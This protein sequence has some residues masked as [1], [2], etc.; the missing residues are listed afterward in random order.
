M[1]TDTQSGRQ[2]RSTVAGD[3]E[4]S[5]DRVSHRA[6]RR[7]GRVLTDHADRARGEHGQPEQEDLP[8]AREAGG[9][10][11]RAAELLR[12]LKEHP[13]ITQRPETSAPFME[14]HETLRRARTL[15]E[16]C[17]HGGYPRQ[18]CAG[19]ARAASLRDVQGRIDS[20]LRLFPI[21]SHLDSTRLLVQVINSAAIRDTNSNG[22]TEEDMVWSH[23]N[24]TYMH[25]DHSRLQN[26][27]F[28]QL[29]TATD[30]F[31]FENQ[32]EQGPL[33]TL[34]KGNLCGNDVT[35]RKLLVSSSGQQL[36]TSVSGYQ[37]FENEV[38]ILPKL[39]HKNIVKLL[40]FCA[41]RSERILV[42]EYMQNGSLEDVIFGMLIFPHKY[43]RMTGGLTV[44]WPTRFRIVEGV[45]QG[46]IYL[47][48]HS[49]HRIIHRDLKPSN[50]LLD[51]DMNPRITNFDLAKIV[52]EDSD[53]GTAEC[54][55]GSVG[56]IAPEYMEKGTY[57]VKTDVYS[58]G[59]MI[60]EII[61]GK[62]WTKPFQETYYKD[63]RTWAFKKTPWRGVKLEQRLKG[64]IHPS[65]HS[66]SFVGRIV[67]RCLSFP[68][69]RTILS[70]QKEVRRC[71]RVALLCIQQNPERRPDM[72]EAAR[73]LRPRKA[74]VPFPR[75]PGY[76]RESPMY[77]GDRA[78]T[79]A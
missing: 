48:N 18:L 60:L 50:V 55:V 25:D 3:D 16:S 62:R 44:E 20:F 54:V 45:A 75:R 74:R 11:P 14:L 52:S 6:G 59:V 66:V 10:D 15:V 73:M 46:A 41:E 2:R 19:G 8:A 64:F 57:S 63:V 79:T 29:T 4:R 31:S 23:N 38:K 21:I 12:S 61:S 32:I 47:H 68:V 69:R 40:G 65:L 56:F 24:N 17:Q 77:A 67:P 7:R 1:H 36:P 71:I 13:G 76:A 33:A 22:G 37:L 9:A 28:S 26:F 42:Y 49:R 30:S 39:Q 35:I 70:Q 72:L 34:Y 78:S 27:S 58:F 5:P 43:L 51:S 53:Q